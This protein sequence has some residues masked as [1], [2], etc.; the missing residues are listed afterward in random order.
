MKNGIPLTKEDRISWLKTL[1]DVLRKCLEDKKSVILG[2]LFCWMLS[3]EVLAARLEKR[4]AEGKHFMASTL[5]TSQLELLQIHDSENILKVDATLAP[6][7]IVDII[8]LIR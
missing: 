7:I 5:L 2:C 3:A 1:R 8:Q 4:A 6:Q